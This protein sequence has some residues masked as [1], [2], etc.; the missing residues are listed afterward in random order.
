MK[1]CGPIVIIICCFLLQFLNLG[2]KW[3][4]FIFCNH[5]IVVCFQGLMF[6]IYPLLGHLA[7]VYLTMYR[8]LNCGLVILVTGGI[9]VVL[10]KLVTAV[11][12]LNSIFGKAVIGCLFAIGVTIGI[13]LFE[14]NAN[15]QVFRYWLHG[16]VVYSYLWV[17]VYMSFSTWYDNQSFVV[18]TSSPLLLQSNVQLHELRSSSVIT[19]SMSIESKQTSF[20]R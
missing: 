20:P 17:T 12:D 10:W 4:A 1:L 18:K 9:S 5:V 19:V 8:M 13:G 11:I 16:C 6:L 7:D 2:Q 15:Q 3:Y 14:A